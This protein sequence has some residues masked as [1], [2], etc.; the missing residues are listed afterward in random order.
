[1]CVCVC[2]CVCVYVSLCVYVCMCEVNMRPQI[3]YILH[4]EYSFIRANAYTLI[5]K[6]IICM[7]ND[8]HTVDHCG[9]VHLFNATIQNRIIY[10]IRQCFV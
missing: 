7:M 4:N 10:C 5:L 3:F 9:P 6:L 8:A 2:V 1:M